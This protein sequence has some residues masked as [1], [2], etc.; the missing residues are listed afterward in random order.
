MIE[1]VSRVVDGELNCKAL[2]A[3][4]VSASTPFDVE[5]LPDDQWVFT[6]KKE[7]EQLLPDGLPDHE[8]DVIDVY[9]SR[10]WVKVSR[11]D[12]GSVIDALASRMSDAVDLGMIDEDDERS[13]DA[14]DGRLLMRINPDYKDIVGWAVPPEEKAD[15]HEEEG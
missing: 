14:N 4:L 6:V 8:A 5:P 15:R 3:H 7:A 2:A 11:G 1:K 10:G 13:D 12:L 9:T